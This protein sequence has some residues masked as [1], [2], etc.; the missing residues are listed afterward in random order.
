MPKSYTDWRKRP[1]L[2]EVSSQVILEV[3]P[4]RRIIHFGKKG[5]FSPQ[6]IRPFKVLQQIGEVANR[7][8]LPPQL[9][10]IHNVFHISMLR[11]YFVD[12]FHVINLEEINL[13]KDATFEGGPVAIQDKQEKNL[14]GKA[15][16][17]IKVLGHHRG[18]EES[19][20][21]L[22]DLM[23]ADYDEFF[24]KLDRL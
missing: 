24:F 10:R 18:I 22:K 8:A 12:P 23:R 7:L 17:L 4:W 20:W 14:R 9:A 5:K 15:G 3:Q 16:H 2:V 19:T 21:D 6:Y 1:I 11:K 13:H